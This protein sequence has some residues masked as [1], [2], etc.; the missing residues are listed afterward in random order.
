MHGTVAGAPVCGVDNPT[1]IRDETLRVSPEVVGTT[2]K[3][4]IQSLMGSNQDRDAI[5]R[6]VNAD[7]VLIFGMSLG[8]TDQ[9]WWRIACDSLQ[10]SPS[11]RVIICVRGL[12]EKKHIPA[13]YYATLSYWRSQ[14]IE[15]AGLDGADY[16]VEARD[17]ILLVPAEPILRVD[18]PVSI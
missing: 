10:K 16:P 1:Q 4:S 11:R 3:P 14:L 5:S 17:R 18:Q 12:A 15:A 6:L 8:V 7:V 13:S 9:R 2:V